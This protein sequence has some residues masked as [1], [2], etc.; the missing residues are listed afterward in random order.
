MR[1]KLALNVVPSV[2]LVWQEEQGGNVARMLPLKPTE[3]H[4]HRMLILFFCLF[5]FFLFRA[6]IATYG[7]S[8]VRGQIGA[9]VA[10]LC[11]SHNN[12]KSE[13]HFIP[14]PQFM[15]TLDP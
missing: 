14:T 3:D 1:M 5:I 13:P 15:A 7:G 6:A 10:S 12:T 4:H 8:Q 9:A 11:R 2:Q